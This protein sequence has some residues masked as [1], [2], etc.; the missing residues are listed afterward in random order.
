MDKYEIKTYPEM[1]KFKRE[2]ICLGY[3][4]GGFSDFGIENIW[5][6]ELFQNIE[7]KKYSILI[8]TDSDETWAVFELD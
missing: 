6:F 7:T 1:D 3:R 5:T 8:V 4:N 2:N